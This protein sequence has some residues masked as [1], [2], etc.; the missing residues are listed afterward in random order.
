M[1]CSLLRATGLNS[2]I[3]SIRRIYAGNPVEAGIFP[4]LI[5]SNLQE[6]NKLCWVEHYVVDSCVDKPVSV[7]WWIKHIL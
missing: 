3:S 5:L 2:E 1:P 7:R 4:F 6:L